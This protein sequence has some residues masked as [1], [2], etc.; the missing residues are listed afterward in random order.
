V[1][2]HLLEEIEHFKEVFKDLEGSDI[3]VFGWEGAQEAQELLEEAIR[4]GE[5]RRNRHGSLPSLSP[6]GPPSIRAVAL[7]LQRAG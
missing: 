6:C 5:R 3:G 1:P 7:D 2:G 4:A